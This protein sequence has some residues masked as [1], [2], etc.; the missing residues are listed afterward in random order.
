MLANVDYDR[1]TALN[2]LV[3]SLTRDGDDIWTRENCFRAEASL[4]FLN[5]GVLNKEAEN[6]LLSWE[7]QADRGNKLLLADTYAK[8]SLS[9]S[10]SRISLS[11]LTLSCNHERTPYLSLS[12]SFIRSATNAVSLFSL[13]L[14]LS[15]S[16]FSL[17]LLLTSALRQRTIS[18]LKRLIWESQK[19]GNSASFQQQLKKL[20]SKPN[21]LDYFHSNR[22]DFEVLCKF[23]TQTD[24]TRYQGSQTQQNYSHGKFKQR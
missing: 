15:V 8:C 21:N 4:S 10:H 3:D 6:H 22:L 2:N 11:P 1:S 24:S 9:L 19:G 16:L 20:R 17:T 18:W 5:S 12:Y 14:S 7:L 23:F 13:T